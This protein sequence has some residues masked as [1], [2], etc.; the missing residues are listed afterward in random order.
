MARYP[1]TI[2]FPR[3]EEDI[4]TRKRTL[5]HLPAGESC[6]TVG[7]TVRITGWHYARGLVLVTQVA[8]IR[9][10]TTLNEDEDWAL[11]NLPRSSPALDEESLLTYSARWDGAHPDAPWKSN[12]LVWRVEF[13]YLPDPSPAEWSLAS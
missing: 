12:P 3:W 7:D 11:L 1:N 8:Q 2:F 9:L 5:V 10:W 6:P 13:R 4:A